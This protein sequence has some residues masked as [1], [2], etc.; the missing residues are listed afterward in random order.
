MK[1]FFQS[2]SKHPKIKYLLMFLKHPLTLGEPEPDT[3]GLKRIQV[4]PKS[5]KINKLLMKRLWLVAKPYLTRKGAWKTWL[6]YAVLL[7]AAFGIP[8]LFAYSTV[9]SKNLT[10][11]ILAKDNDLFWLLL[12]TFGTVLLFEVLF[13]MAMELIDSLLELDWRKWLTR[14]LIDRYLSKR[15]YYDIALSE[16]LDNPDQRIQEEVSP[17]V[18]MIT[19]TPRMVLL[20]VLMVLSGTIILATITPGMMIF[21][22]SYGTIISV[23]MFFIYVPIIKQRFHVTV[24][25]ADLRYGI[26][27]VRDNAETV[28]FYQG[29]Y[30]ENNQI[31]ARLLIAIRK[32][33][34]ANLYRI[35]TNST[36]GG[37]NVVAVVAPYIILVPI[38]FKGG[39][40][41]G[42]IAQATMAS[43]AIIGAMKALVMVI[44][45][46]AHAAPSTVRLADIIE[47]FN[48][49]D[50]VRDD[51]TIPHIDIQK[52]DFVRLENVSM[53][54]PGG[55]QKLLKD[56]SLEIYDSNHLVIIGQTGVGK[57]SLLRSMAGLWWR[58]SGTITMPEA[59][60]TLFLPQN[61]YMILGTL[62]E[63]LLYPHGGTKSIS[64]N[65]LEE[66]LERVSLPNLLEKHG[67]LYAARNWAKVLSLG[68]QQRIGF[69]RIIIS[70]PRFAFLDEA[71]SAVDVKTEAI[72]YDVLKASGATY[73]SVGHRE[74][75]LQ[76]HQRALTLLPECAWKLQPID[77]LMTSNPPFSPSS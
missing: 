42:H 10:N 18:G 50:S 55:E 31:D 2:L 69:A 16:N 52:G 58:G 61:P 68:E 45:S 12:F 57:S 40:E 5:Y 76:F 4:D 15:T 71:T 53:E 59:S 54:T 51:E 60:Q 9:L 64:D 35:F 77:E 14:H 23:V 25:E 27:H 11:A 62:R 72:L 8:V 43:M 28:A 1:I 30:A 39:I 63:Q 17:F 21:M 37:F 46:I 66:V 3:R 34:I 44:P 22:L 74:S 49:M 36:H 20:Q 75:I 56:L 48:Q 67:G 41:Y 19:S 38:F 70:E 73:V 33:A 47:R 29:E 65:E 13:N 7:A 26:L 6:I 32:N 24:A